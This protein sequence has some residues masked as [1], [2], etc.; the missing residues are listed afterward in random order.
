M[1]FRH[2]RKAGSCE[3]KRSIL[4]SDSSPEYLLHVQSCRP[5]L[6]IATEIFGRRFVL[7]R[8]ASIQINSAV[9]LQFRIRCRNMSAKIGSMHATDIEF[10]N[11]LFRGGP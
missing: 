11:R 4:S 1:M 5:A 2:A 3:R 10:R 9:N 6:N 8:N 7:G